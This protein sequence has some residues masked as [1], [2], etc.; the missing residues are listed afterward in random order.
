MFMEN[1]RNINRSHIELYIKKIMI[2]LWFHDISLQEI[3][4]D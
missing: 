2:F 1:K 4:D 3:A